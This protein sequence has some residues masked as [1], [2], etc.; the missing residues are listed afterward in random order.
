MPQKD[1]LAADR[2]ASDMAPLTQSP[3]ASRH[4]SQKSLASSDILLH[5]LIFTIY[6]WECLHDITHIV[7]LDAIKMEISNIK[8][9]A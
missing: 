9:A 2:D 3:A 5:L 8:L 6:N 1:Q 7:P 4:K